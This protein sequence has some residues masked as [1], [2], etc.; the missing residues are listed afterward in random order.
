MFCKEIT[1]INSQMTL[2]KFLRKILSKT[3]KSFQEIQFSYKS[4]IFSKR[5]DLSVQDFQDIG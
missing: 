5:V 4:A 2:I 1:R 3:S